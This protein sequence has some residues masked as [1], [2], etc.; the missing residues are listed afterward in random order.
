MAPVGS[1]EGRLENVSKVM[2]ENVSKVMG[3]N[4][5]KVMGET[6]KMFTRFGTNRVNYP[7][8]IGFEKHL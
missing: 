4:V 7:C 1:P 8:E 5:T 2:G 3:E 6:T